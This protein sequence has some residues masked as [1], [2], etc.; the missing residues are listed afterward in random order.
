M[1]NTNIPNTNSSQINTGNAGTTT[2]Q[3]PGVNVNQVIPS[4]P[5]MIKENFN[6]T[7]TKSGNK[8]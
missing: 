6:D 7:T 1:P 8:K 4:N 2:T 3:L 5:Q